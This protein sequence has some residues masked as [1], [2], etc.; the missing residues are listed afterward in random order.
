MQEQLGKHPKRKITEGNQPQHT[1]KYTIINY[2]TSV[3]K[4]MVLVHE[5]TTRSIETDRKSRNRYKYQ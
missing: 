4:S 5:W 1:L 3:I 2:K